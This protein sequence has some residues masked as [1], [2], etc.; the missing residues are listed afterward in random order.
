MTVLQRVPDYSADSWGYIMEGMTRKDV[1]LVERV[2]INNPA[3]IVFFTDGTKEVVKVGPNDIYNPEI[4]VQMAVI[5]KLSGEEYGPLKK[6][7]YEA[8]SK[9]ADPVLRKR[10]DFLSLKR[11]DLLE[12]IKDGPLFIDCRVGQFVK[13]LGLHSDGDLEVESPTGVKQFI[14]L[15]RKNGA[16]INGTWKKVQ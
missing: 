14:Y 2:I 8:L 9:K 5:K 13:V 6:T 7:M 3:T 4:G 1:P 11:G 16:T 10:E 12:K 15:S